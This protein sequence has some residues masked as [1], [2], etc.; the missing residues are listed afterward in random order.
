MPTNKYNQNE[1]N[2]PALVTS[3]KAMVTKSNSIETISTQFSILIGDGVVIVG[4]IN[5]PGHATVNGR[6]DGELKAGS[7]D[8]GAT[9]HVNGKVTA[10]SI[11]VSGELSQ[12]I[13]CSEHFHI[14]STGKVTGK[15]VYGEIQIDRGGLFFGELNQ[16]LSIH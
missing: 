8:V 7:L 14:L 2:S 1:V 15:L 4:S 12:E 6:L 5:L 3:S 11:T 13:Y 10:K 16:I 9:G